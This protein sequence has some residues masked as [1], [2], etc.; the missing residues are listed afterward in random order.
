MNIGTLLLIYLISSI[1]C[2]KSYNLDEFM[3]DLE[4]RNPSQP[5]FIQATRDF[6]SSIIDIVN[7]KSKYLENRILERITQPNI[8]HEF[9][10]EWENDEHEIMINKGY[11]IQFNNALGPYKG[12][13][14]FHKSVT[15]DNLKSLGF[16][17]LFTNALT[18]L[19][20]GSGKGGSDFDPKGKSDSEILRFC[21][22]FM[23][24]LYKYI[25]PEI[26]I[27]RWRFRCRCT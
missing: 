17:K 5:E 23:T 27:P 13:L 25:G 12:G 8:I 18:G 14:R 20:L 24:S 9:K 15:L 22:S 1:S 7:S 4:A 19:P 10:V 6:I 26:D 16:D 11:R 2:Y 21:K 3:K